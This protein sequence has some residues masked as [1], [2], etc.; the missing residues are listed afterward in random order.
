[1]G[2]FIWP[3]TGQQRSETDRRVPSDAS[4]GGHDE[5]WG[6]VAL[7]GTIQKGKALHVQHV[8]LV[9]E[10]DLELQADWSNTSRSRAKVKRM[11]CS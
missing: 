5:N 3:L 6:Q 2:L 9:D 7:Q 11:S 8:N 4:V 10:Q 1:M